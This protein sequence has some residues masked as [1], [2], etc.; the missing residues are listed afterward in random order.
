[1]SDFIFLDLD[2]EYG[3]QIKRLIRM[4]FTNRFN[5][6]SFKPFVHRKDIPKVNI[7]LMKKI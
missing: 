5:S 2:Y 7:Y 1:M 6:D 3:D 4:K